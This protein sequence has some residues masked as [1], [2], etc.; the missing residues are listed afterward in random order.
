M[1]A[2]NPSWFYRQVGADY[3]LTNRRNL[4][5]LP[6]Y[7]R[8]DIRLSEA[9]LFKKAKLTLTSEVLNLFNRNNLRY[10]GFFGYNFDGR[11]FGQMDRVL[12]IL[13]SA[14]VVIEF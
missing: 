9:F 3:F 13:P 12:P 1:A 8:A 10:A 14:G 5:R 2:A 6:Y 11:V 7:S 4:A